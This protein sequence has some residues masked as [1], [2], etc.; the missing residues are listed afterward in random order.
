MLKILIY[1]LQSYVTPFNMNVMH[2]KHAKFQVNQFWGLGAPG[3]KKW[4]S[5]IDLAHRPY[6]SVRTNVLQCDF[7]QPT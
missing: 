7:V 4:P 6:N 1:V 2:G 3:A 5:S